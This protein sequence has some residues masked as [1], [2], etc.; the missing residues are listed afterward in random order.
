MDAQAALAYFPNDYFTA[1]ARF[2]ELAH[3]HGAQAEEHRIA[4]RGPAG[5]PLSIDTA[6]LG[7]A[8][9]RRL[10]VV[11]SGTHG[12]EAFAGSALQQQWLATFAPAQVSADG[13]CLLIH[14]VNP[15]GFAWSRRTNENNVDLNRNALTHFPG[16]ANEAYR[17]LADWLNPI[18]APT[19]IDLFYVKGAALLL[20]HGFASLQQGI[21][22]GQY[23]YPHGLFYGGER[24]E[25]SLRVVFDVLSDARWRNVER[26]VAIDIHTGIGRYGT[27]KL[28]V[29]H[30][31][32][33]AR[34][35]ELAHHFGAHNVASNRPAGSLA[36]RV[37][38][39]LSERLTEH[40]GEPRTLAGVFEVGT[41]PPITLLG[42]LRRENRVFH[43]ARER[44]EREQE[45]MRRIFCPRDPRWRRRVLEQGA[46]VLRQAGN[47]CFSP[48]TA[49]GAAEPARAE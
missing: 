10:L 7:A 43:H 26:V 40:F 2:R 14:A 11:L 24:T 39:G 37:S 36:Y 13:G 16:P 49:A 38:G 6:Y 1:R 23:E 45:A 9:P 21:V 19:P 29:D 3:R 35:G 25:E 28:M 42:A 30:A 8:Q 32:N 18:S 44:H 17:R 4:A 48:E 41:V 22:E 46:E 33:S 15:F 5:E 47:A 34:Y 27:Y 12:V 20:R 31:E